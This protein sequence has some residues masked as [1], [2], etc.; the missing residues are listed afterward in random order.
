MYMS[1][2][3]K[4]I[5]LIC[6]FLGAVSYSFA[7]INEG[8]G[9]FNFN[10]YKPLKDKPIRVFYYR[11]EGDVTQMP[12]LFVM[13]GVLRNADV[14]R[15]NWIKLAE[16]YKILVIVPEFSKEYYPSSRMYNF[17]NVQRKDKTI[18]KESLWSF[19]V[20]DPIF[21]SVVRQTGSTQKKYDL[22][23]HSA[24]SQF[25]HRF[26][27]F[28]EHTK[29]NRIVTANAGSYTVLDPDTPFPYGIKDMGFTEDR[30]KNLLQRQLVVQLGEADTDPNHKQLPRSEEAMKQGAFRLERGKYFYNTAKALA[31]KLKVP[32][33]WEIRT[34][35]GVAHDN[36]KMAV[37]AAKYLYGRKK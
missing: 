13:H 31:E 33:K 7:Q 22:F 10:E 6:C 12:I 17:G 32:F 29:A 25:V 35:P 4:T 34:V 18:N 23:G 5:L 36:G 26:F 9:T 24:G 1:S 30:L 37:D 15:D 28:K 16:Q 21:D 19:S 3:H 11:P 20:I 14:Y 27:L 8:A 2:F